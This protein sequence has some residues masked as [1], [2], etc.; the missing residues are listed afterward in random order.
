MIGVVGVFGRVGTTGGLAGVGSTG[1]GVSGR[2]GNISF[3]F[4]GMVGGTDT[5]QPPELLFSLIMFGVVKVA[6]SPVVIFPS[7]SVEINL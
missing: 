6:S 1:T 3:G 5:D 4:S 2:G 7:S